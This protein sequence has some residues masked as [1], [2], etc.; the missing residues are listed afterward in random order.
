MDFKHSDSCERG[1]MLF[2]G[3]I[4][5]ELL[6]SYSEIKFKKTLWHQ[7]KKKSLFRSRYFCMTSRT[8][9]IVKGK[10]ISK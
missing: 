3:S 10:H 5:Q 9:R 8:D 4:Q 6:K 1:H 7:G 2:F